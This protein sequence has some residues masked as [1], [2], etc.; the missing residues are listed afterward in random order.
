V[1]EE[2]RLDD[3]RRVGANPLY[4]QEAANPNVYKPHSLPVEYDVVFVGQ[5]YADRPLYIRRLIDAGVDVRVWGSGWVPRGV[6]VDPTELWRGR[7]RALASPSAMRQAVAARWRRLADPTPTAV[8]P[9]E[10]QVPPDRCGPP[11]SDQELIEMY[12]RAKIHLGFSTVGA[13][14]RT[15]ERIVQVR[16]RDFEAPMSGAFYMVEYLPELERFFDI[17]REIVCYQGPEDL[18]EKVRY[19]LAHDE[20]RE[21]IR[22]AGRA[23]ALRDHTWQKRFQDAFARMGLG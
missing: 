20:E 15:G 22:Q 6:R 12:S 14:H 5:R 10:L 21:R 8:A 18:V 13:T 1:P 17:G 2:F 3:Y 11:L 9:A 16:L 23:R 19:F 7:L 4:S